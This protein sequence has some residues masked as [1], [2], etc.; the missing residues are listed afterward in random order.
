[1]AAF[2]HL[3]NTGILI[4]YMSQYDHFDIDGHLLKLLLAVHEEGSIT[5]AAQRLGVTQSAVSHQMEKLRAIVGDPLFVKAG[6]G[7]VAT[8]QANTLAQRA[9]LLLDELR[10]FSVAVG[11]EPARLTQCFTIAA[12]DLQRDLLLPPLLRRLRAQAP[13]VTLRVMASGAPGPGLLRDEACQLIITPRPPVGADIL[14]KRLFED[15]YRVFY[16]AAYRQAP[17]T[18]ADYL[19]A[20]HVSVLYEPR[21]SL[22]LDDWLLA[23]GLQRRIVATVPAMA[24]LGAMVAGGTWV[25]TAPSRMAAGALRGLS[26]APVPV[27]TPAM[28]MYMVWHQRH[29]LDPVHRWLRAELQAVVVPA[30][31]AA[32]AKPVGD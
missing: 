20:D 32:G 4:R 23:K 18:R 9:R 11:F 24:G 5:R 14:Q 3:I 16:D 22:D 27:A 26:S 8:A 7:I 25:A 31:A 17:A 10:A 21:R 12:N 15:R 30:L 19:A 1:M 6:R 13:G 29:Q 28:P 2:I